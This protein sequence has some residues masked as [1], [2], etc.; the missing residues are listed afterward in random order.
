VDGFPRRSGRL[1]R[2]LSLCVGLDIVITYCWEE[3][4]EGP[5][6]LDAQRRAGGLCFMAW[7][8]AYLPS[9]ISSGLRPPIYCIEDTY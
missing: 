6:T 1:A 3:V 7:A 2:S 9:E 8:R 4:V 5:G